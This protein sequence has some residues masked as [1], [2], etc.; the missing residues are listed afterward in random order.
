M[1]VRFALTTFLRIGEIT[2]LR[3]EALMYSE[4]DGYY[5]VIDESERRTT[6]RTFKDDGTYDSGND[7]ALSET[8]KIYRKNGI[9][10]T[11]NPYSIRLVRIRTDFQKTKTPKTA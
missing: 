8:K 3:P 2:A 1:A 6:A 4:E 11:G 5:V 7:D 9:K 10:S